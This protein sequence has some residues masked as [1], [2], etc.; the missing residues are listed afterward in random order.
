[1]KPRFLLLLFL[2]LLL[3]APARAHVGSPDVFYDGKVGPWPVRITIR[4]PGVVPGRA[5]IIAQIQSSDPVT[6]SFTPLSS[7]IA[8][9]NAPPAELAQPVRGETNLYSGE[10]WLMTTDAYSIDVH[11]R[12]Q[13]GEGSVQIPVNS[14]ATAQL[15]LPSWLGEIL[16]VLGLV[17]CCGGIAIVAA[18]AGESTLPLG[19][20]PGKTGRRKYWAAALV[21]GV[22]LVVGKD[23]LA[24]VF[25]GRL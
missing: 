11:V 9:S 18:A 1:M 24:E 14:V 21:T 5:E 19:A 3:P 10:L 2:T 16:V 12:G 7:R 20:L 22:V 13:S 23:F 8:V 4:M 6:V 17:L 25:K 15:P